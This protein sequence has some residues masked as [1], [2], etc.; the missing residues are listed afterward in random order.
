MMYAAVLARAGQHDSARA[1]MAR[2]QVGVGDR[3]EMFGSFAFD[4]AHVRLFLGDRD[5][6]VRAIHELVRRQ[7]NMA[8]SVASD[9]LFRALRNDLAFRAAVRT[10]S[11]TM[12]S[13]DRPAP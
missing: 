7:P 5:G 3:E 12:T 8:G 10:G 4:E 1:V 9:H 13:L 2:A 6:A 11:G